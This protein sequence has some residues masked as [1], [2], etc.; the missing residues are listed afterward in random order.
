MATEIEHKFCVDHKKW[1]LVEKPRPKRIIQAYLHNSVERTVRVRVKENQGF[2]TIKG[3]S[4]GVSRSEFEYE[5]P[6]DEAE[7]IISK[8]KLPHINKLRYE[9]PYGNHIWEIDVFEGALSGL[10]LAEVELKAENDRFE[11]PDFVT[12]DVSTDPAY[13]N[14]VLIEKGLPH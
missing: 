2:I 8:F 9:I 6:R 14:A 13:Y 4:S 12:V 1:D 7:E 11:K 3:A 5:I 10:I